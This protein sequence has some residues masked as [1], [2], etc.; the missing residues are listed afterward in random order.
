MLLRCWHAFEWLESALAMVAVFAVGIGPPLLAFL[1]LIFA[2]LLGEPVASLICL[3]VMAVAGPAALWVKEQAELALP[4]G[5]GFTLRVV[6]AVTALAHPVRIVW[7]LVWTAQFLLCMGLGVAFHR[8]LLEAPGRL[9]F[10]PALLTLLVLYQVGMTLSANLYLLLAA[11]AV[12]N[13]AQ[14]VAWISRQRFF[15]DLAVTAVILLVAHG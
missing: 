12:W 14:F 3:L 7:S 13:A 10:T 15:I 9:G 4:L 8:A 11:A 5:P 6:A 2:V 1:G